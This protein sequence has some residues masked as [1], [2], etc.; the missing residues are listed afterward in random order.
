MGQR[1]VYNWDMSYQRV[2]SRLVCKCDVPA[3]GRVWI[4]ESGQ[5][6]RRCAGCKTMKW[7]VGPQPQV[8]DAAAGEL[9][10]VSDVRVQPDA[11]PARG[12]IVRETTYVPIDEA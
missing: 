8:A 11:Q 2:F 5:L 10:A 7:D 6:P 3:C 4:A 12:K 9:D 1:L